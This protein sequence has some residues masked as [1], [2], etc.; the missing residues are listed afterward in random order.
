ML[1]TK[2][3]TSSFEA[4]GEKG[5]SSP[6]DRKDQTANW[7]TE[8]AQQTPQSSFQEN[9]ASNERGEKPEPHD[10]HVKDTEESTCTV[11]FA[12]EGD[13]TAARQSAP[14]SEG[15]E[16]EDSDI[17]YLRAP[18]RAIAKPSDGKSRLGLAISDN[19]NESKFIEA[20]EWEKAR[21]RDTSRAQ[22]E[23]Y[24]VLITRTKLT[25]PMI[26][27]V[28]P[29]GRRTVVKEELTLLSPGLLNLFRQ[30][31]SIYPGIRTDSTKIVIKQPYEPLFFYMKDICDLA[32]RQPE[33]AGD[34]IDCL[35][36]AYQKYIQRDHQVIRELILKN[37]IDY[38]SLWAIFKPGDCI[39]SLDESGLPCLRVLIA[40]EYRGEEDHN[41]EGGYKRFCAETWSIGWDAVSEKFQRYLETKS[42]RKF[43]GICDIEALAFYP[44]KHFGGGS[45]DVI[46]AFLQTR[47]QNGYKWKKLVSEP[48]SCYSYNGLMFLQNDRDIIN[49]HERVVVD[50]SP[51]V[52]PL[53]NMFAGNGPQALQAVTPSLPSRQPRLM[54]DMTG[55]RLH[56]E[57]SPVM[58]ALLGFSDEHSYFDDFHPKEDFND[59]QAQL[60]PSTL[61]CYGLKSGKMFK[62]DVARLADVEWQKDSLNH[63]ELD[64]A[65]K[66]TVCSLVERH[67]K[68]SDDI[69]RDVIPGKGKGLV[70]VLHGPP[71]V[72]KTLTAETVAEHTEKPLLPINIGYLTGQ[73]DVAACLNT[74]FNLAA[75]WDAIILLDEADVLLE[76]RSYED[77]GRNSLVSSKYSR[78]PIISTVER[79]RSDAPLVFLRMLEYFEG[80]MFMTTNRIETIDL[81]FQSRI[82]IAIKYDMLTPERRRRIWERF[83]DRLDEREEEAKSEL[84]AKLDDIQEWELNGR[85]I[86]NVLSIAE[87]TALNS[88]QRRGALRYRHVETVANETLDFQD[89]FQES[90]KQRKNQIAEIGAR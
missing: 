27:G 88:Q 51:N 44:L 76:K 39:Y 56:V 7:T 81:A 67:K 66:A 24:A 45:T 87:S 6:G 49:T 80:I 30:A 14:I 54:R 35:V 46:S 1:N 18:V 84:R 59:L 78:S 42:I 17:V 60:C 4:K 73:V 36:D 8:K 28:G 31:V 9:M 50:Q 25:D 62:A 3:S 5:P 26:P 32:K 52:V 34:D 58:N 85:Q 68:N 12:A 74:V 75:R 79:D 90:H 43:T 29:Y 65:K 38:T 15:D 77:L 22:N 61:S 82:H 11:E 13:P 63:L 83:I 40:I 37:V 71:G 57:E 70:I 69:V 86:R 64:K 20:A 47:Q 89:F 53:R 72:G 55:S 21:G 2:H 23:R 48:P 10:G 19:Y 16:S 33:V 41:R